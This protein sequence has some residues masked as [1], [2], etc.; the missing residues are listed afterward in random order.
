MLKT[1]IVGLLCLT[2]CSAIKAASDV[3]RQYNDLKPQI[4]Q[5]IET[6]KAVLGAVETVKAEV[7]EIR[8]IEKD[9][10]NRADTDSD[11]KLD[12]SE[13]AGYLALLAAALNEYA[14]RKGQ[15]GAQMQLDQLYDATHKPKVD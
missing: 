13:W 8:A 15:A 10:R 12:P 1:L 7:A 11:G 2:G 3:A 6:G 9:V 5:G 4:E 14:R